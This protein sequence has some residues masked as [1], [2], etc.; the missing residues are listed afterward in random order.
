VTGR[1]IRMA[2]LADEVRSVVRRLLE[3]PQ[4]IAEKHP[5]KLIGATE[6][7]DLLPRAKEAFPESPTIQAMKAFSGTAKAVD[8]VARLSALEGAVSASRATRM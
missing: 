3:S 6:F 8:V 1:R 7:K 5:E 2:N 4:P